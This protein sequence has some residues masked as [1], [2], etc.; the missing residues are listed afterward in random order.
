[1]KL[2]RLLTL[3]LLVFCAGA[4]SAQPDTCKIGIYVKSFYDLNIGDKS[5]TSNFWI[6]MLYRD[7][8]LDFKD[9]IE[10]PLTKKTEVLHFIKEKK[11]GIYW[12]QQNCRNVTLESW[13][14]RSFPFDKQTIRILIESADLNAGKLVFTPDLEHSG[15]DPNFQP[16]EWKFTNFSIKS[17]VQ[18]DNTTFGDPSLENSSPFSIVEA[19]MVISRSHSWLLMFKLLIGLVVAYLVAISSFLIDVRN[20]SPRFSISVGAL[21]AAVANKHIIESRVPDKTAITLIDSIHSLT[22]VMIFL[23]IMLSAIFLK[24]AE[25]KSEVVLNRIKKADLIAC[26]L[27]LA[28]YL[29]LVSTMI[30]NAIQRG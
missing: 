18:S 3:L 22:F 14:I 28:V 8:T 25:N 16:D 5:C 4:S 24:I 17:F 2:K 15:I 30:T 19:D 23:V 12:V 29:L 10:F 1:M 26:A 9:K 11:S 27:S 13:D 21:F 6:W 7:S 20:T